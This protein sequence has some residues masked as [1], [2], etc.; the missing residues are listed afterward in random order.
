VDPAPTEKQSQRQENRV[1][2]MLGF[3]AVVLVVAF[4]HAATWGSAAISAPTQIMA[5]ALGLLSP[6]GHQN[7]I[8]TCLKLGRAECVEATAASRYR[9]TG[10]LSDFAELGFLQNRIGK[11]DAALST[12]Q[13]YIE[14]GGNDAVVALKFA[15]LL[16]A[17][18]SD[19]LAIQMYELSLAQWGTEALP[20]DQTAG[21]VRLLYKRGDYQLAYEKLLSFRAMGQNAEGYLNSEMALVEKAL[22]VQGSGSPPKAKSSRVK[23][24]TAPRV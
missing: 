16:E 9:T 18:N 6:E 24:S 19:E 11:S 17:A 23:T 15:R 13:Q 7:L 21:L 22:E 14:A 4:V 5:R 8:E 3:S 1:I 10:N 20:I 2:A 12:L